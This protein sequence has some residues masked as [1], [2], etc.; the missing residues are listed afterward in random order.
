MGE[1]M[2]DIGRCAEAYK[3]QKSTEQ[4]AI[5]AT[6]VNPQSNTG[7]SKEAGRKNTSTRIQA[8]LNSSLERI[9]ALV[10]VTSKALK[11]VTIHPLTLRREGTSIFRRWIETRSLA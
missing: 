5:T 8:W 6:E 9:P 1:F 4:Q 10:W 11:K 7:S 2:H 3:V